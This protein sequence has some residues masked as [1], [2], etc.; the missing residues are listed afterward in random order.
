MRPVS[1]PRIH[2]PQRPHDIAFHVLNRQAGTAILPPH[3]ATPEQTM[4]TKSEQ[5]RLHILHVAAAAFTELGVE[6]TT[7]AEILGRLGGSKSTIYSYYP[8]KAELVQAV[9]AHGAVR[10][11][12]AAFS[13]LDAGAAPAAMLHEFGRTYLAQM[14]TPSMVS[15]TRI[16][17]QDGTR[18]ENGR[19]FYDN[20]PCIGWDMV[21][22]W[23]E[24]QI[25]RGTLAPCDARVAA[26]HLK[27]LLQSELLDQAMFG[28]PLPET[29]AIHAAADRAT[30]A[31]LRAY[32][33]R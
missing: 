25:A 7:M 9:V 14:L 23:I 33:P 5:R 10:E 22:A 32:L 19:R 3:P 2:S 24:G 18:S 12:Q 6:N 31:F 11:L 20:G 1:R 8:S 4:R 29:D 26:M 21:R 28:L 17:Q 27:G 16:A 30:D 15:A 13:K